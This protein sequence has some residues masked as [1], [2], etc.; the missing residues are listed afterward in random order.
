MK[1]ICGGREKDQRAAVTPS[2][3][4]S[5]C[6]TR[7]RLLSIWCRLLSIVWL[8]FSFLLPFFFFF[9]CC[10]LKFSF[11]TVRALRPQRKKGI[12]SVCAGER[13]FDR[14]EEINDI[15]GQRR[16]AI[17]APP[18]WCW[19]IGCLGWL[20]YVCITSRHSYRRWYSGCWIFKFTAKWVEMRPGQAT[21]WPV[22]FH[23]EQK[24][25]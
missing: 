21:I 8:H 9:T 3:S 16:I 5:S 11:L 14:R 17:L 13:L 24:R 1:D 7:I 4:H 19:I 25:E 20:F 23:F 10:Y 6:H 22:S 18:L 2:E 12:N 15:K